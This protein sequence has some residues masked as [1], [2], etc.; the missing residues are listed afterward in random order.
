MDYSRMSIVGTIK[1]IKD[2]FSLHGKSKYTTKDN[3]LIYFTGLF[4]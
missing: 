2:S 4:K 3:G 1:D